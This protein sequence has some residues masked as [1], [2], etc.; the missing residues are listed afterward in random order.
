MHDNTLARGLLDLGVDVQL[1]PLYTPITTDEPDVTSGPIFF[2]GINVYLQ[3]HLSLFRR[4]P[5]VL[6]RWLDHPAL[7]RRL[8]SRGVETDATQLGELTLSML[9]GSAGFQRKEVTRLCNWLQRPPR[10][11]L[12][13][14]TNVLIAGCVPALKHALGAPVAVTLQGDDVFLEALPAAYRAQA[15]DQI[16]RLAGDVDALLVHSEYYATHMA[17]YLQLDRVRFRRVP[18]G[19]DTAEY[20]TTATN[21]SVADR[22]RDRLYIGYLARIAPEKGLHVLVD[23]FLRLK[24]LPDMDRAHLL[25]AGW[26]G[27]SHAAYARTQFDRI[28]A[29]GHGQACTY[30]GTID[31]QQKLEFLGKLHVLSVPTIY[32][33]P[34]GLYVLEALAAGVPVVQPDHGAFPELLAATGGGR[35]VPPEDPPALANA[36]HELLRDESARRTLA[37]AGHAA[38]HTRLTARAMALGTLEVFRTLIRP[39]VHT[40]PS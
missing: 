3:Q 25:V 36:L 5:H 13:V 39:D 12:L 8:G 24:Q 21:G 17:N 14:L 2:G 29:A 9:K 27:K 11:D 26:L 18:L 30:L 19:I 4:F 22:A 38:V 6:D 1:V 23:A 32:R 7:L 20:P 10:P 15:L 33:E 35:L 37:M 34:K 28:R 31:R 16:R 40:P